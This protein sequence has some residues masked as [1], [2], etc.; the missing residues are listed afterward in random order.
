[1]FLVSISDESVH[2]SANGVDTFC[3]KRTDKIVGRLIYTPLIA[4]G[5]QNLCAECSKGPN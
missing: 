2:L 3:E 5:I 4:N 1:M